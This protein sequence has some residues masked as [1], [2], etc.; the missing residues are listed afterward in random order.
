MIKSDQKRSKVIPAATQAA[1]HHQNPSGCHQKPP[2]PIR[3]RPV[4]NRCHQ[5][6]IKNHQGPIE[7]PPRTHQKPRPPAEGDCLTGGRHEAS[8]AAPQDTSDWPL[9]SPA[10]AADRGKSPEAATR[11][12]L[13]PLASRQLAD[14]MGVRR[15]PLSDSI[16]SRCSCNPASQEPGLA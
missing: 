16:V 3:R 15:P 2:K 14:H 10:A 6:P 1:T 9:T 12:Q 8:D 4:A 13:S 5:E 7:N 11:L